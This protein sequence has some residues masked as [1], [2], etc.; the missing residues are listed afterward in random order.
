[1]GAYTL[2]ALY[3]SEKEGRHQLALYIDLAGPTDGKSYGGVPIC[4][5]KLA[6]G[7][8]TI[9]E[10][11]ITFSTQKRHAILNGSTHLGIGLQAATLRFPAPCRAGSAGA[12]CA[13]ASPSAR[14]KA[15]ACN[16]PP[17]GSCT[18]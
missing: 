4:H 18:V 14:P 10:Q 6:L 5:A 11:R 7:E 2:D 8:R 17:S 16:S 1:M 3:N 15:P 9:I 13:S 12:T